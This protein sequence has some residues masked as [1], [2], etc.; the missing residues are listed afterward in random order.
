V[1]KKGLYF[2]GEIKFC[3]SGDKYN[4][5]HTSPLYLNVIKKEQIEAFPTDQSGGIRS[6]DFHNYSLFLDSNA[7][8]VWYS[9]ASTLCYPSMYSLDDC[10][11]L[12]FNINLANSKLIFINKPLIPCKD[13][14]IKQKIEIKVDSSSSLI[15]WD[16]INSGRIAHNEQWEFLRFGNKLELHCD[17]TLAYKENWTLTKNMI[18][19]NLSGFGENNL[20]ATGIFYGSI[21]LEK[22]ETLKQICNEH[23]IIYSVGEIDEKTFIIK[24]I[25]KTGIGLNSITTN[26]ILD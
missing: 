3:V 5:R 18:P 7:N 12:N 20:Y 14:N 16:A 1:D 10:C 2:K 25:D 13:S 8:V 21:A 6:G 22:L 4:L 9:P 17:N 23:N 11:S 15:Y 26:I 19:T 24:L